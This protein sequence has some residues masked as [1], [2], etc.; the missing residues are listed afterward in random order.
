M[1]TAKPR[2]AGGVL[3][4]ILGMLAMSAIAGI[5]VTAAITPVVALTGAAATSAVSIFE[6]LPGNLKPG[7]LALPTTLSAMK[8]GKKVQFA[9]FYD[10]DREPVEFDQI[11]PYVTDALVAIEDPRFY[12]HGGVDALAASRAVIQNMTGDDLSGASTITMQYVRNVLVQEATAI[13]NEE[14]QKEAYND[15]MRQDMDRK[16]KE[17][18]LAIGVEKQFTKDEIITGYLNITLFGRTVYGIESAAHYYFGTTAK[19]LTLPQAASLIAIVNSPT[20]Y[21]LDIEENIPA[22]TERRN[23]IL[24]QMLTHGKITQAQYDEAVETP[25]EP[26]IT[27]RIQGC[28]AAEATY[29]LGHFCDYVQRQLKQDP[30]FGSDP[31]TREFNMRR[32]GYD[33]VTTIDLDMQKAAV[34]ATRANVAQTMD[35]IDV[36]SATVSTEVNTG[37]VLVMAQNR[38]FSTDESLQ[39]QGYTAI[40]YGTDFEDGGSSGFQVGSTFKPVTLAE[41][42]RT[43]HSV[44]DIVNVSGRTV[45]LQSFKA[46]CMP[47]GVYGY[48]DWKFG[49]D[50]L[51]VQGNQTVMTTIAQSLNGGVVSM[52]QKMDLCG[53][54]D[55]AEKMGMHRASKA[56]NPDMPNNDTYNLTRTPSNTFGG[57]DEM[58]PLTMSTAYASFAGGG[59]TCTPVAIDSITGPDGEPVP[60]QKSTCSE[61]MSSDV[62]A[63]V[64]YVL[65]N[66]ISNGLARH[67]ASAFGIPHLAKTGTTDDYIDN[68]TIGA[69]SKVST[70][71]WVGNAAPFCYSDNNCARVDTRNFGGYQGLTAADSRIWPEVMYVADQ[72]YGGEGFGDPAAAALKQTLVK[73]PDFAGQTFEDAKSALETAG[74]SVR[75]GG[76]VD[77]S[78]PKGMVARTDPKAGD[79]VPLGSEVTVYRSLGNSG[80]VPDG[81][82]GMS[83]R[84]AESALRAANFTSVNLVC[85]GGDGQPHPNRSE[86]K[87]V[88]PGSGTETRFNSTITLT[89]TCGEDE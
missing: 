29:G 69:S 56:T 20:R 36:G 89:V 5:L 58:S 62:A 83:G 13:P 8:D 64:A 7:Q 24:K 48:G 40:N 65:Q 35:G 74:F 59:T 2:S 34:D 55:M 75:D 30:E 6:N 43:G 79:E 14:A 47:G 72:K 51:G 67:A 32:G 61:A 27:P 50:N 10:Q 63:G 80:K 76:E 86:V 66:A 3:G 19:D 45:Q 71:T 38:P 77:S 37:R 73:V 53:T 88:S 68:W 4:G 31:E 23:L 54:F 82:T 18:K 87:S 60:F 15:A 81:L 21:Q 78:Q 1:R 46:S 17:M 52:Q 85:E 33:I 57:V 49:N 44:R 22:N 70:A 28:A 41:W 26:K 84:D 9:E 42:I 39:S 16:L 12:T 11:S 25:V